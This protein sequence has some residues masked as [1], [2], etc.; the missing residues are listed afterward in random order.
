MDSFSR[1]TVGNQR[2]GDAAADDGDIAASIPSQAR[3]R[4]EQT[5]VN[6]PKRGAGGEIHYLGLGCASVGVS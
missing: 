2:S 4:R 6:D 5:V 1:E 3:I